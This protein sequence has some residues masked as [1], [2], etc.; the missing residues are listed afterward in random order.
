MGLILFFGDSLTAGYGLANVQKESI[1]ALLQQKLEAEGLAY[2]TV[3]AGISGDTSAGGLARIDL[4]L[5]NYK[6]DVFVLEL[7]A[8][9]ILRSIPPQT[10]AA[11]LAAI[12]DKVRA[13]Y[14]YVKLLLLGMQ[15]PAFIGGPMA[16]E[17]RSVFSKVA[18]KKRMALM[19][20]LLEGVAGLPHLNMRDMLHP[21][22]AG[23]RIIANNIW[24]LLKD[25][26]INTYD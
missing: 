10:T 25:V 2:K 21:N 7:G 13:K 14:P 24:P 1:P 8:N 11:N 17:F 3:N 18:E 15:I 23:Y 12:V 22:A 26:L 20:F 5:Q 6:P 9:D 4:V 16:N 19:P